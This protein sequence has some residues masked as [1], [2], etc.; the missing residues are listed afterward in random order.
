MLE[1]EKIRQ[2]IDMMVA[3]DLMEI[4]L[5]DGDVEVNLRRPN[6]HVGA[7]VVTMQGMAPNPGSP[8]TALPAAAPP[9]EETPIEHVEIKSPMVGT[10]YSAPDPESQPYVQIGAHVTPSTVVCI[11]EAMKVFNEIK[12]EVS[13]T[14]DRILVKN[15]EPIEYGQPLFRVRPD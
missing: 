14:I 15:E 12:A 10:Y 13:G 5:R 8:V 9:V 2:L 1:I 3:N 4:S 11:V 7:P 6:T